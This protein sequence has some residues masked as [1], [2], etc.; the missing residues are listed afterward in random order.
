MNEVK[1][2]LSAK[3]NMNERMEIIIKDTGIGMSPEI[4]D[5]LSTIHAMN[6]TI[7]NT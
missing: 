4:A 2:S 5:N 6:S 7:V 1:D 3:V